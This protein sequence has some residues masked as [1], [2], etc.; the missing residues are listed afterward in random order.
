MYSSD[1]LDVCPNCRAPAYEHELVR[2]HP[3]VNERLTA[4]TKEELDSLK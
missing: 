1:S 4:K 2:L 3:S